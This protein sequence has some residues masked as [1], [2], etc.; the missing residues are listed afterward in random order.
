MKNIK[1]IRKDRRAHRVRLKINGTT[2]RPRISI[3]RTNRYIYAQVIDDSTAKTIV[4][5]SSL[6]IKSEGV[7][8]KSDDAREVGKML[9]D[10]LKKSKVEKVVF[11]RGSFAYKGRL[12]AL[13]EALRENGIE[14]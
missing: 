11:D 14:V 1:L 6:Q 2:E 4:S 13:A 8:T 7:V 3:H 12:K 10:L 5:C 9:A